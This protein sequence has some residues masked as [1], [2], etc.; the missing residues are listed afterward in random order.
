VKH[1]N[2]DITI[3]GG[4]MVGSALALALAASPVT[5]HLRVCLI[6]TV[7]PKLSA[8]LQPS[9]SIRVSAVSPASASFFDRLGAW[10]LMRSKRVTPFRKMRVWHTQQRGK[11]EW[12]VGQLRGEQVDPT[13]VDPDA[14][15]SALGYIVENE[16][17]QNTLWQRMNEVMQ[18]ATGPDECNLEIISPMKIEQILPG[19][20]GKTASD[21]PHLLLA[22]EQQFSTRLLI[23]ADGPNSLVKQFAWPSIQSFG[24]DY[25]Q[26]AV[27]ATLL[28]EPGVKNNETAFQRFLPTGPIAMLPCHGDY[29][30]LV[31]SITPALA[32][33]LSSGISAEEFVRRV[34]RAFTAPGHEFNP[35]GR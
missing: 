33:E 34:N 17:I 20:D 30:N 11:V 13:Q 9:P 8:P 28:L 5:R 10:S 16:V 3:V 24:K 35:G 6:E 19:L 1:T 23:G 14:I 2:Y 27:V 15:D 26:R 21:W 18:S 22:N 29:A 4:G 7:P 25:E 32:K 31:W 12:D